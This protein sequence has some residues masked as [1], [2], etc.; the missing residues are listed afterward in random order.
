M[1]GTFN[2][3]SIRGI[4]VCVPD[5]VVENISYS[6]MFGEKKVS[7]HIRMTGVSRRHKLSP[8][9]KAS[10][11]AE[12]AGKTL[13]QHFL[14]SGSSIDVLVYVTQSPDYDKP[15]TAFVLQEKLGIKK[16]SL[17]F[18]VNLGCSAFVSG[19]QI[20]SALLQKKGSRGLL[21]ISD[22]VYGEERQNVVDEM[23]FGDAGCA[24]AIENRESGNVKYVQYS[25]GGRYQ[26]IHKPK[27][28]KGVMDGNAVFAFTLNDVADSIRDSFALFQLQD[29]DIDFY[30][31]HQ[32]QKMILDN[33]IELC[34]IPPE[35][36]LFSINEYGNTGGASIPVTMCANREKL[37]GQGTVRAYMCGF[38]VGLAWGSIYANIE[39]ENILPIQT[40]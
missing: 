38:G 3:I 29:E 7:K 26:A 11:L 34:G 32:G 17:V 10:D 9:Q 4:S 31:L 24:V 39:T 12:A 20:V 8:S 1:T 5:R 22:G 30:F 23:L 15:S 40:L 6:Q 27:G 16:E 35:K 13:L 33:L 25:D 37:M 21:L 36:V 14:W 28:G 19:V 18:D 2:N